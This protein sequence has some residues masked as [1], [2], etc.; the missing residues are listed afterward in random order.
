MIARLTLAAAA[1]VVASAASAQCANDKCRATVT[2]QGNRCSEAT[3]RVNPDEIAMGRGANKTVVWRFGTPGFKFCAGD[4]VEFKTANTD[5]Q[6]SGAAATDSDDGDDQTSTPGPCRKNFR[7]RNKNDPQTAGKRYAYL[8]RFT[9]P[10][11]EACVKDPF[12]K[13]G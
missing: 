5:G 10:N 8:L 2:V 13:N 12:I 9:G 3:I 4:G 11:G 7:V 6:F 1:L